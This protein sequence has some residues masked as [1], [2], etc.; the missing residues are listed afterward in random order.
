MSEGVIPRSAERFKRRWSMM[1]GGSCVVCKLVGLLVALGALNWGLVGLAQ[2]DL[3]EKLLGTMTPAA[4]AVYVLIG[5]AG[6]L[7]VLSLFK[8]CPCQKGTCE[9]K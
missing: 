5:I 7:K 6:V 3:V 9:T 1:S 2:M 8:C 4:R